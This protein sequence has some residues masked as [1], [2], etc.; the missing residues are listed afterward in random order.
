MIA[1]W[2]P[3]L[4]AAGGLLSGLLLGRRR[5][6]GPGRFPATCP[7]GHAVSFHEAGTGVCHAENRR[8]KFNGIG[9]EVGYLYVRCACQR[10]AG[11]ELLSSVTMQPFGY[12]QV[13]DSEAASAAAEQPQKEN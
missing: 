9:E 7:C 3:I 1:D 8:E 10:Y 13:I 4:T 2:V 12:R 5:R 6:S 11:P